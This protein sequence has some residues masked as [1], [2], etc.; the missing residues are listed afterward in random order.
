VTP[1]D[2]RAALVGAGWQPRTVVAIGDGESSWTFEVDGRWIA[3]FPR[4]AAVARGHERE[5]RLFPELARHV[6]FRVPMP[7]MVGEFHGLPFHT[8]EKIA[9]EPLTEQAF[10]PRSFAQ[11]LRGLH[12]FPA[13]RACE[14][15]GD[16]GT[17]DEWRA[18]YAT[19]WQ[20]VEA[21]VLPLLPSRVVSDVTSEYDAF[22]RNVDFEPVLVHGDLGVEHV[23]VGVQHA[24]IDFEEVAVGDPAIDF[25]GVFV[26]FGLP[27]ARAVL[28]EY[29]PTDSDLPGRL[30]FYR[31]MGSVHAARHALDV[32]DDD[33]LAGA[34][35]EVE[36][37]IESRPRACAAVL[38]DDRI[39]MVRHQDRFWTL[40]GG[41]VEPGEPEPDAAL[42]E[43]REEAGLGGVVVRELYRRTY[44]MGREVCFL[45]DA[46]D[47]PAATDDPDVSAVGWLPLDDVADDW[48]VAR[49]RAALA[50]SA[51]H[52]SPPRPSESGHAERR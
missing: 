20:D 25:V 10:D 44:G 29:G 52:N 43:L 1:D 11:M 12:S 15:L 37:R 13:D 24:V 3:Q 34:L 5:R 45:V 21:H 41:G 27:A 49:V 28:A 46:G 40:P 9:G 2:A 6:G 32:G 19:L 17:V 48:Q 7:E 30:R 33:L 8:Y 18:G 38:R 4:K 35:R 26:A 31:W 22:L 16:A 42:R 14:L 36:R 23:L 50:G 47:E 39:L 51:H